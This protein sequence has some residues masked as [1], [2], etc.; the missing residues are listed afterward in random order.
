MLRMH[1]PSAGIYKFADVKKAETKAIYDWIQ[2]G[3]ILMTFVKHA[4]I[5]GYGFLT[6]KDYNWKEN[7]MIS[8]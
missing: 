3:D 6:S 8:K 2:D 5:C 4:W 7:E 1:L